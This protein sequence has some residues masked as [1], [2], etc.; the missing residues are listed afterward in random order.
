MT[1]GCPSVSARPSGFGLSFTRLESGWVSARIRSDRYW[2]R[3]EAS[4]LSDG[5]AHLLDAILDLATGSETARCSWHVEPGEYRWIFVKTDGGTSL[6]ILGFRDGEAFEAD[7]GGTFVFQTTPPLRE[8]AAAVAYQ[9]S[10]RTP[11][12]R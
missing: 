2:A 7:E 11:A 5:I 3:I 1:T 12:D 9:V 4:Y 6:R 8:L 10:R